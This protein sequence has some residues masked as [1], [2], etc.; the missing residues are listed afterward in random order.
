MKLLTSTRVLAAALTLVGASALT[1]AQAQVVSVTPYTPIYQGISEATAT[2]QASAGTAY[3]YVM[4]INLD[5]PGIS[6]TTTPLTAGGSAGG[7]VETT[8]QTTAQFLQSTGTQVAINANTFNNCCSTT[9]PAPETLNGLAISNGQ[10]VSPDSAGTADLLL[11]ANNQATMVAGGTANLSGVANA[12]AG[13]GYV[14][15]NG[16]NVAS[17]A[18][19]AN[20][21]SDPRMLVGLSQNDQY[22][23]L[24]SVDS[25]SSDGNGVT[26]S[27]EANIMLALG[28]YNAINLDGGGSTSM[29]VQGA[30]GKPDVLESPFTGAERYDG[31]NLGVFAEPLSP[32]PLPPSLVLFGTALMGLL[33]V[34]RRQSLV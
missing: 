27:E 3:S 2:T 1:D 5:A 14:V 24:V 12:I 10:L 7:S 19:G 30:N 6:F 11:T 22:L 23:Y 17:A 4:Q 33:T 20:T 15:Q 21:A 32:V 29:V 26:G 18:S 31:N 16:V 8:S 28:A 13:F 25:G 34:G 9:A